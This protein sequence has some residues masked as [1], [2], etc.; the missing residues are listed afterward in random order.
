MNPCPLLSSGAL[1][2]LT[3]SRECRG[4]SVGGFG[5]LKSLAKVVVAKGFLR[6]FINECNKY[7]E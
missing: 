7:E 5:H 6:Q 2:P 1:Q 4:K 3:L